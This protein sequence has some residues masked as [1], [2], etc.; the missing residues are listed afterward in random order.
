LRTSQIRYQILL[1]AVILAA[2][3]LLLNV[4]LAQGDNLTPVTD[5]VVSDTP[6]DE[7]NSVTVNWE[8]SSDD[9]R[10]GQYEVLRSSPGLGNFEPVGQVPAGT[11]EYADESGLTRGRF[12]Y[13]MVKASDAQGNVAYSQIAGPVKPVAQ[14]FN[15][16]YKF[17]GLAVVI[18]CGIILYC[19]YRARLGREFFIRRIAGLEA[20]DEAIGRATEM[21]RPI[22]Y[23][24]GL[25]GVS[26]ISTL[27]GLNIL[28]RVARRAA[29]YDTPL[30]IPGYDPFVMVVE[31]EI[32]KGAHMDA[33]RPDTY[34]EDNIY[35][36]SESQFA[37]VAAVNGIMLRERPA[38]IFYMGYFYAESLILAETGGST[39]AI[40]IAGTDAEHQLPF[41][42]AACDYT[43]IGEELYAASAYLS[44]EPLL[45]GSLKGQDWSKLAL[46]AAL[47]IGIVLE[48]FGIHWIS[49]FFRTL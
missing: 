3:L 30:I 9:D 21:G 34:R 4:I 41:F 43:L 33:G 39:G 16:D 1:I 26:S 49:Y 36:V 38:A 6:N 2:Q 35:F 31:R 47:V 45:L 29:E 28:S 12:Y 18:F 20:V 13:Y 48:S 46:M 11:N 23:L 15:W 25:H 14:W 37:Y 5:V 10:V 22:L 19:I 32:V 27:A 44:R 24:T 42:I 8:L 40:Q 7:G 17:V